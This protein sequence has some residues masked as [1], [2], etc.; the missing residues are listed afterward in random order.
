MKVLQVGLGNNPGGVEAFA[1]NYNRELAKKNVI[2]DYLCM[3]DELAYEEEIKALGGR[4]FYVPNVKRD[5]FGYVREVRRILEEQKYDVIHVNMLSAANVVPLRLAKE[6]GIKKII[7]HSHNASTTGIVRKV[8]HYINRSRINR[9]ANVK[10]ACGRKAAKFLY[11]E[12]E[13]KKSEVYIIQNAIHVE[14]YIFSEEKR[15]QLRN[16]LGWKSNFVIGHVGRFDSQK[17]HM[18]MLEIFREVLKLEPQAILCL[19]GDGELRPKIEEKIKEYGIGDNVHF[20]GVRD[21]V[22]RYFSAMDVF[23]FPSL[24]EGLPFALIEAQANGLPCV[25][26]DTISE[27]TFLDKDVEALSLQELHSVWAEHIVKYKGKERETVQKKKK[28]LEEKGFD[29][30]M[31]AERLKQLYQE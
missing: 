5:Y 24:Y 14:K 6:A 23:L 20:A 25:V 2:F 21:D 15:S 9:L 28:L 7:A 12:K 4:V 16:T 30:K 29:I 17:N 26:S 1:I 18:E 10:V 13:Y 11:G 31:E 3:Y 19:I 22:D 8:M 27:E